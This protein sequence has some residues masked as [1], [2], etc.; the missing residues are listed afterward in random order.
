M[1]VYDGDIEKVLYSYVGNK[2]EEFVNEIN[3]YLEVHG[4]NIE[5]IEYTYKIWGDSYVGQ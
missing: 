2:D 1:K 4:I 5:Y 3:D